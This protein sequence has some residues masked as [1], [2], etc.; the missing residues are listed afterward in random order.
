MCTDFFNLFSI[1]K[2][3]SIKELE[4]GAAV[5]SQRGIALIIAVSYIYN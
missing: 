1:V 4:G 3:I 5:R 2:N